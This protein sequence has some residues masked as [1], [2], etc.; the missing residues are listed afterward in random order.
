MTDV[1]NKK[2]ERYAIN[3][4]GKGLFGFL[5]FIRWTNS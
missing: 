5:F 1:Q 2:F 3:I 4:R